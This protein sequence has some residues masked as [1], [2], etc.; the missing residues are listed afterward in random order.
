MFLYRSNFQKGTQILKLVFSL[1]LFCSISLLV[2][3]LAN[4]SVQFSFFPLWFPLKYL[5]SLFDDHGSDS[6]E[7]STVSSCLYCAF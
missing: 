3:I 7:I 2:S 4:R 6:E 1:F 5:L